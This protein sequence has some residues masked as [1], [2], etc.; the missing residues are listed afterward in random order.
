MTHL[1]LTCTSIHNNI[2]KLKSSLSLYIHIVEEIWWG[3]CVRLGQPLHLLD[4][5]EPTHVTVLG[6]GVAHCKNNH[7]VLTRDCVI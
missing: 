4:P 6:K 1:N 3:D 5:D 7:V 2:V